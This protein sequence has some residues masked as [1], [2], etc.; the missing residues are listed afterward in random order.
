MKPSTDANASSDQ[1]SY[2]HKN[3]IFIVILKFFKNMYCLDYA[4]RPHSGNQLS[5]MMHE[6][7]FLGYH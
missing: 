4:E 1:W 3:R 7:V 6:L 5:F 2:L